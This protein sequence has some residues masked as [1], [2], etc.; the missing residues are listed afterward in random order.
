M[1]SFAN[2]FTVLLRDRLVWFV[3][4]GAT[5]FVVEWAVEQRQNK[6]IYIDLPLV[7]K[8]AVQWEAQ[9]KTPPAPHQL[10]A[11]IEGYIREEILVREAERLGLDD[12]DVII[13][14]RLA[15]KL[16]FFLGDVEPPELPDEEGLRA[17]YTANK[18]RYTSP[19][20]LSFQHI[21]ANQAAEAE[22]LLVQVSESETGWRDLGQPFMLNREYA[23]LSR[24][25]MV[26][27]MGP[28]F[29]DTLFASGVDKL[30]SQK[31]VGPIRSAFGWH[32]VKLTNRVAAATPPFDVMIEKVANDWL[33]EQAANAK[34]QAWDDIRAGY[35]I[36]MAPIEDAQ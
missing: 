9:T 26:Q 5:L 35:R 33:S 29:S 12:Q 13:R 19:E 25:D 6:L 8:L 1:T 31:W 16:E 23:R 7:E 14:R 10:D 3:L 24:L 20:K 27:L 30:A 34:R 36:E 15:Q 11:L 18:A 32:V 17:Y 21:F 28:Q 4:I 22:A 2:F